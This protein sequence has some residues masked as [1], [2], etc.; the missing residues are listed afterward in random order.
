MVGDILLPTYAGILENIKDRKDYE[1]LDSS[2][3][4]IDCLEKGDDNL[5][6]KIHE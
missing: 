1:L 5:F 2:C 4:L 3:F 6:N